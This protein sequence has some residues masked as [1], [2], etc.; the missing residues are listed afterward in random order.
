MLA[1]FNDYR[2]IYLIFINPA[3]SAYY[4]GKNT[5]NTYVQADTKKL[6]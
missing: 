6:G 1:I 3:R 5:K 2:N 4:F